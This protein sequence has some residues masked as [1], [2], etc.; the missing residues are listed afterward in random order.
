MRKQCNLQEKKKQL[1]ILQYILKIQ[2]FF[3]LM[4]RY[5]S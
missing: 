4:L 5:Y 1:K 2:Y 3:F